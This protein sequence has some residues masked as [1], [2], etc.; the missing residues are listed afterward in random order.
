MNHTIS[1]RI[2]AK[3]RHALALRSLVAALAGAG[4]MTSASVWAQQAEAT[5]TNPDTAAA[6]SADT[7]A[8]PAQDSASGP[9]KDKGA[10]VVVSGQRQAAQSAQG[11]KKNA[12]QVLDSIVAEDIGKFPD[13][14]VAEILG[15]VTGVQSLRSNGE[16]GTIV[17]RGLG[18]ITTLYNGREMF[19]GSGRNLNLTDVPVAML[20]RVDV[21][22]SQGADM[23]EGGTSGVV[24]VRTWRPFD[25]K[26]AQLS[27][28]ARA[29]D[30]DKTDK[31]DPQL[32]AL[33]SNRWKTGIGDIGLLG[34][35][36]YQ[37]GRYHD[38][39]AWAGQPVNFTTGDLA[40]VQGPDTMGRV[41]T[42]GDR[43]RVA[44]NFSAQWR[45]NR[46]MEFYA[47]GFS[48]KIDHDSESAYFIA[49]LPV[50]DPASTVT[51]VTG[52]N[53]QRYLTSV[54][55]PNSDSFILSSTQGRREWSR[56][57]QGAIGG[58][59][60]ATRSVRVSSE[61]VRT[62]S[63][64]RMEN[65]ILDAFY[66]GNHAVTGGVR[67]GG[68]YVDYP[69]VDLTDP[70][71]WTLT[72]LYDNHNHS[73]GAANDWRGDVSWTPEG[74]S[75]LKELSGGV[76]WAQR[77]AS[78]AHEL[79]N[80]RAATIAGVTAASVPGLS[81]VSPQIYGD[82]GVSEYYS[83]C[84]NNLLD[85]TA[86]LRQAMLGT[87][88]GLP[89]DPLSYFA[90]RE[91]TDALYGKAKI[92]FDAFGT[93]VDGTAGVRVVRTKQK[94]DG[95]SRVGDTGTVTPVSVS[96]TN[97]DVLPS[98]NLRANFRQDLIGRLVASKAV[99][100]PAFAD[101]N[102][103]MVLGSVAD[104][105]TNLPTGTAGNPN[106]KPQE[107]RN[108]D[109]ALEWY[110]S[111]DGSVTGTVFEHNFKNYLRH[112]SELETYN[113]QSY[114]IDRPYNLDTAKLY[115]FE[116]AYQQF[117]PRL[118]GVLSGLGVQANFTYMDGGMNETDGSRHTFAGMSKWAYNLVGLYE[119]GP[120]SARIAYS[121]RDKFV[122]TYNYRNLGVDLIVEP[123]K[124]LDASLSY[125]ISEQL[126]VTLDGSN[127]LNQTYH[128][129]HGVTELP[130]DVRRYD[131]VVG[132]AMRFKM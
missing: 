58:T 55:N 89:D 10:T 94:I 27:V 111:K 67:D 129:Y 101:Y 16:A 87:S 15:R 75:L 48:T 36:S 130:R 61:L 92:G 4:I 122:D 20:Q 74:D 63:T 40:G 25:F 12:E 19:T 2:P 109:L 88:A 3:H 115:G 79:G 81:C 123:I 84:L 77:D 14:N 132:L 128:D 107:A 95:Y 43:K 104:T 118:P 62:V 18:G 53:G 117:F 26:G 105:A 114:Y 33:F 68:G 66:N 100:R 64:Y 31:T 32:G 7:A 121:W 124:T 44:A 41:M 17:I 24:D 46:D 56:G 50:Y 23:V 127:L 6:A 59:W 51:T 120:W 102:P 71:K 49:G 5:N 106:L 8:D 39:T 80:T 35:L 91:T 21:Y 86:A 103:G 52:A 38:E 108:L 97:T 98:L 83:A 54:S 1:G 11:I 116:G 85:N 110:F 96:N 69:G 93:P 125:K 57:S 131:R 22:K 28:N 90:F 126:T 78:F 73:N 70:S 113:G 60:D 65:P 45:P 42:E 119:R 13:K 47:E 112:K 29:E 9:A 99:E 30:R 34:G 72:T 37:R 82:Y 76:R